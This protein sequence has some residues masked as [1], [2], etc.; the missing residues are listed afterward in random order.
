MKSIAFAAVAL[1]QP[2]G[3]QDTGPGKGKGKGEGHNK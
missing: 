1:Y 3:H 2:G